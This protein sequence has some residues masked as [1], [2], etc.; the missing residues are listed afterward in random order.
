MDKP[1]LDILIYAHDGRGLGHVSRSAAVGMALRRLYPE[2]RVCLITGCRRTQELIGEAPLDWIKL[3]AYDTM[4][5]DGRS[6]GIDGPCGIDDKELGRLRA[7]QIRQVIELYR[8]RLVLADH[9]PQGKHRELIEAMEIGRVEAPQWVLGVRGIVGSVKQAG[10][11]LATELYQRYFS[12]LLWYGDRHVLGPDHLDELTRRF[13]DRPVECGYV[14][15]LIEQALISPNPTIRRYGCTI[16][17]PWFGEHTDSFFNKLVEALGLLGPDFGRFR[18]FIGGGDLAALKSRL[19]GL[20]H[21]SAE[22]FGTAYV[23]AL[24][25]SRSAVVFGGYNS[26]ID[27]VAAGVPALVVMRAMEDREQQEHLAALTQVEGNSLA[28]VKEDTCSVEELYRELLALM[29]A[30][31]DPLAIEIDLGGA[32]KSAA[33]LSSML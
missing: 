22:P 2:L 10:S 28:T 11:S 6:V 17:I 7:R 18:F 19:E 4:V 32:E 33:V 1:R 26:V 20:P 23:E 27:A 16:S 12:R 8:P 25:G 21:C 3:P 15:R 9:T 13:G 29:N 31:F 30:G 14:S 24:S 5:I